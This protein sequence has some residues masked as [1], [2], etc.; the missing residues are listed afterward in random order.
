MCE[1]KPS[2]I[3]E[4]GRGEVGHCSDE[5]RVRFR[6]DIDR[7]GD[8]YGTEGL[9]IDDER[10]AKSI[11]ASSSQP[12]ELPELVRVGLSEAE[13]RERADNDS[14]GRVKRLRGIRT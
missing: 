3:G 2:L 12:V 14:G 4:P 5:L 8:K 9:A 11:R 7:E 1:G 10:R 6:L 13:L